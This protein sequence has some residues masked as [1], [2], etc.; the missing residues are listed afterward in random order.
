MSKKSLFRGCFRN[1]YRKRTQALLKSSLQHLYHIDW[2]LATKLL[3]EKSLL[4]ARQI[5]GLLVNT[6]AADEKYPILNRDNLTIPI[7]M[8]LS[9]K[10]KLF[11]EF[12]ATF[13]K[14]TINFKYF[15]KRIWSLSILCFPNYGLRKRGEIN[16][17]KIPV[18]EDPSRSNMVNVPKHCSNLHHSCFFHIHWPLPSQLS[19]KTSLLLTCQILGLLVST[20]AADEMYLLLNRD[21]MT[22]S[23]QMQL[24]QKKITFSQ[25]FAAFLKFRLNFKY[26]Q[27]KYIPLR[28]CI[29]GITD[30][31]NVVREITKKPRL[32]ERFD[33]QHG[34]RAQ[35]LLE[36]ASY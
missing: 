34:K 15:E 18:S 19:W 29:S 27:T 16:V 25:F 4:L 32:R 12:F 1:Q 31:E 10:Q 21:N 2:S 30:S 35:A 23:I 11:S 33:K 13:L 24:S 22:I 26:S 14:S 7:Q 9:Q 20:L 8:Q 3:S 6:L 17:L 5:L 36:S 28:F